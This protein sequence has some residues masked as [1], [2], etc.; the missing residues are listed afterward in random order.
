MF[1]GRTQELERLEGMYAS[2]RSGIIVLYGRSGI[3]KTTLA[4]HF[5]K[6]KTSVY[7]VA[8]RVTK[9]EQIFC[10]QGEWEETKS[11]SDYYEIL[12]KMYES[13]RQPGKKL[14]FAV[15]EFRNLLEESAE[16]LNAFVRFYSE[17]HGEGSLLVLFLSSS[18][19]W[20]ENEMAG[21]L[22]SAARLLN[23]FIKLKEFSFMELATYHKNSSVKEN[24]YTG[25]ILG[26]VPAYLKY[27]QEKDDIEANIIRLFLAEDAPLF[28]EA[29]NYLK[30]GLREL[31]AYNTIL[32][33]LAQGKNKLNDVYEHTGF[34]RAKISVYLKNL[35]ELDIT[36][37]LYSA[38]TKEYKEIKKGLY[39]IREPYLRFWYRFI[40]PNLS[41]ILSGQGEKVYKEKIAPVLTDYVSESFRGV[42]REYLQV[43]NSYQQLSYIYEDFGVWHGKT[44]NIDVL[45]TVDG[46]EYLV[47]FCDCRDTLTGVEL[48]GEYERIMESAGV[49]P[50]ELYCFSMQGFTEA[51]LKLAKEK[52]IHL[53]C[54]KDM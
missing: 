27:W 39:C 16:F 21:V 7:Y 42:C 14:V 45:A 17:Y 53:I 50:E 13:R 35:T 8:R 3:G 29:E 18:V 36:E 33:A 26:G 38:E 44:G 2:E 15:D 6:N 52:G 32:A 43:L 22:G 24:I 31:S 5:M 40:Y 41:L 47:G 11:A 28:R 49:K 54:A 30:Q 19:N 20:V 4:R 48:Y 9:K 10:M 34:S 1:V 12:E 51:F 46:G 23:G 25:G 37:K